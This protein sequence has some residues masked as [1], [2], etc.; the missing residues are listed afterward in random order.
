MQLTVDWRVCE[1]EHM[2]FNAPN[3]SQA[4][5]KPTF[6]RWSLSTVSWGTLKSTRIKMR[7]P[8][9]S[10]SRIHEP[11][12]QFMRISDHIFDYCFDNLIFFDIFR[13]CLTGHLW[14]SLEAVLVL[15]IP[16]T[17]TSSTVP[18][19]NVVNGQL[20]HGL[21]R[22]EVAHTWTTF[23]RANSSFF[24]RVFILFSTLPGHCSCCWASQAGQ[25]SALSMLGQ[26]HGM[27]N[28][29]P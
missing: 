11:S 23:L 19:R 28:W 26:R 8:A 16:L 14:R 15:S 3:D 25:L 6:T 4:E 1:Y 22:I 5:S 20:W 18:T 10:T 7:L 12:C 21:G 27:V 17:L 2:G 24:G 13:L 29:Q 9:T